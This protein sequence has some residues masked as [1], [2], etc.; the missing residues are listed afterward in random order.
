MERF[1]VLAWADAFL[2]HN[3]L[4]TFPVVL[5][6]KRSVHRAPGFWRWVSSCVP[7]VRIGSVSSMSVVFA[8]RWQLSFSVLAT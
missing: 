8:G 4:A 6:G 5:R 2:L 1:G 3:Y 7:V